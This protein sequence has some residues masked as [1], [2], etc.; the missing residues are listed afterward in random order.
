MAKKQAPAVDTSGTEV[1]EEFHASDESAEYTDVTGKDDLPE[2]VSDVA[3]EVEE[4]K[5]VKKPKAKPASKESGDEDVPEELKGKTPAQLAKMYR[6]AQAVIGRQGSELG[7]L[8]KTADTYIKAHL[9]AARPKPVQ[10]PAVKAPDDVDF[11]TNPKEAI[12]RAVAEHPL[13]KELQ[14]AK[15][16]IE[17]REVRRH[18]ETVSQKFNTAHPDAPQ[19]INNEK[20]QQWVVQSPVRK[21]M[22]LRAHQRYDL[23]AANELFNTWKA[24]NPPATEEKVVTKPA[25]KSVAGKEAARVPSGGNAAPRQTQPGGAEG[26]IYRR[27]DV[28]RLMQNDPERYALMADEIT[29]AYSENRVR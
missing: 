9:D 12:A 21:E 15:R 27:A 26:K 20:F 3:E 6:E 24:L 2:G 14:G 13:V 1:V 8:R 25:A 18:M 28:I 10:K 23:D 19:I 29:R 4:E 22:L 17:A 11:F 7:D 5:P 16:D